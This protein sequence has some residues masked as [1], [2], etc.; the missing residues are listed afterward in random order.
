MAQVF[1][2]QWI[3]AAPHAQRDALAQDARIPSLLAQ[4][5]L[6][7]GICSA[8][9][10]GRFLAPQ[11]RDLLS[12]EH[13]P[14]A[15]A[16]AGRLA[17]AVAEGRR[18]VIY[19]DYDVDGITA[20]AILYHA[21]RLAG[22]NVDFYV[23]SR[24]EE[25][26]GLNGDALS[27]LAADGAQLVITVDCGI[28]AVAEA[29][30]A[31]ELGVEL[32]ITDHHTPKSE[33]PDA[34]VL[35]HPSACGPSP[36]ADLCGAGVA[37]KVAWALARRLSGGERVAPEYRELLLEATA[38]AALGLVADVAPLTGENRVLAAFGLRQL[39][40]ATNPGLQALLEVSGLTGKANYSDYD[41]GFML[42]PR[43]NAVG[44]MGHAQ[45][46]VELFTRATPQR[47]REIAEVLDAHNRQRQ[48]VEREIVRAAE[49]LVEERG[50]NRDGCHGIVLAQPDWHIGVLGIVASRLVERFRRPTVMIALDNGVGQGSCRSIAHF[51]LNDVLACCGPHLLSFGGHAMAAG[52]RLRAEQVEP[53]TRAFLGE[54]ARRLTPT[55]LRPKLHIDDEIGLDELQLGVVEPLQRM[56]PFG[57]GNARPLLA[58]RPVELADAPRV[59]GRNAS[60]L[61]FTV[62]D[63]RTHRKAIAFNRARHADEL[64]DQRRLRVAF[65]PLLNEWNGRQRVEM[66]VVDWRFES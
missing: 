48:T 39:C 16:A 30:R 20:S 40:H 60:H 25:G 11:F 9:A 17:A 22:G 23:P 6:N 57:A 44:R 52:V 42:A 10:I 28:T 5:F 8:A 53:F 51:P 33:L 59:V 55:D 41:V 15:V 31:R 7:R 19:G 45:L 24:F 34:A 3:I 66:R 27:R 46:A 29:R 2:R 32:I 54:A 56:A 49:Q 61:Q 21:L 47:A 65:E 14:G 62:R 4:I 36:N 35:V 18:I 12:P 63:G 13:L 43:L 1:E 37:L 50:F 58:T 64:A 38:L 26:Y